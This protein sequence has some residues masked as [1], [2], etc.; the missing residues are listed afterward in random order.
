M[1]QRMTQKTRR[2]ACAELLTPQGTVLTQHVVEISQG[3]VVQYY[4]LKKE[5]PFTEWEMSSLSL[6]KDDEGQL[7]LWKDN[8]P[9]T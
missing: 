8:E 1:S 2:I 7:T 9:I 5:L 4:P 6:R 3:K